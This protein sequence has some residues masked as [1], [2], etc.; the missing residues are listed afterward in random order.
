M[1]W[2][3][4]LNRMLINLENIAQIYTTENSIDAIITATERIKTC[5]IYSTND[6]KLLM[7]IFEAIKEE[8]EKDSNFIDM[9]K[10]EKIASEWYSFGKNKV[11]EEKK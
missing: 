8:V 7:E 11:N 4:T 9:K 3:L 6:K 2:L 1:K 10:L 5:R